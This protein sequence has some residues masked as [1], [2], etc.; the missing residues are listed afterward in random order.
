MGVNPN[1]PNTVRVYLY[2]LLGLQ[3]TVTMDSYVPLIAHT[4]VT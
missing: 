1:D 3:S 2:S 4:F